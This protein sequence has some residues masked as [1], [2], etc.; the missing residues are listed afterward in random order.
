MLQRANVAKLQYFDCTRLHSVA[1]AAQCCYVG[2]MTLC[3]GIPSPLGGPWTRAATLLILCQKHSSYLA[4]NTPHN[5]P[6]T[7]L[8]ICQQYSSYFASNTHTHTLP[9]TLIL[10]LCRK[11]SSYFAS[12]TPHNLPASLF[13]LH[14]RTTVSAIAF[15][16]DT[17]IYGNQLVGVCRHEVCVNHCDVRKN[18]SINFERSLLHG[19]HVGM[20]LAEQFARSAYHHVTNAFGKAQ[21]KKNERNANKKKLVLGAKETE[22]KNGRNRGSNAHCTR[23]TLRES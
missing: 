22:T 5:L 9:A 3:S 20:N 15:I 6:A 17:F 7:L 18:T 10:I 11:L 23:A 16:E 4:R 13:I 1:M 8:I 2:G 12:N 21:T 19:N 14:Y